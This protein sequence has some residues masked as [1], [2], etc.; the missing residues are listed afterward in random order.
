MRKKLKMNGF[1]FKFFLTGSTGLT[2]FFSRFPE[3][4]VKITTAWKR[5]ARHINSKE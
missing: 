3:E 4:T 5:K 2:G 1:D